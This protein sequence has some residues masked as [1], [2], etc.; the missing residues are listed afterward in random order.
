V[1]I[2]NYSL[3]IINCG[4]PITDIRDGKSYATVHI[5]S[6]CWFAEN[7]DFGT[8]ISETLPQHDNCIPEKYIRQSSLVTRQSFYQWDELMLYDDT[9]ALQG[10]CPPG[11]HVPD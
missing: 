5:G 1:L 11:W 10:L 3:L 6:Q 4:Q 8:E 9:P 2:I 7:L